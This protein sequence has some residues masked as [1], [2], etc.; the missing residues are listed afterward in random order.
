VKIMTVKEALE[1]ILVD[2]P[3]NR[4]GEVVDFAKFLSDREE[5]E[6]WRR[7]GR[8]QFAKAYADDEPEYTEADIKPELNQ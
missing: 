3:E 8:T 6:A 2:L 5:H 1:Q 7:F 4:L